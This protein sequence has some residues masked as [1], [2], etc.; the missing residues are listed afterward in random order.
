[1]PAYNVLMPLWCAVALW[2]AIVLLLWDNLRL[3]VARWRKRKAMQWQLDGLRGQVEGLR[4]L[5][6][7]G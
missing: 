7:Q 6:K 2:V 4:R 5:N 3:R 1:M